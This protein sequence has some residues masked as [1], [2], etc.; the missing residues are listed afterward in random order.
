MRF[1]EVGGGVSLW[2]D[3][4]LT[5]S[6]TASFGARVA[7]I[8]LGRT[9]PGHKELPSQNF[10]TLTPGIQAAFS[11][12]FGDRFSAVLRGRLNYLFYNVDQPQN[13]GY[14]EVALGVDY[15]FGL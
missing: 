4:G 1:G 2:R 12:R 9:F 5:D 13:L 6:L 15:A 10:F 3:F 8:Y 11:W 7:F 14:T